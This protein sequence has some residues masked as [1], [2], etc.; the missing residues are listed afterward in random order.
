MLTTNFELVKIAHVKHRLEKHGDQDVPAID[1]KLVYRAKNDVLAMFSSTLKSSLY[2]FDDSVQGQVL[3]DP[4]YLPNVKNPKIEPLKWKEKQEHMIF[5]IHH[6][7]TDTEAMV[8][9]DAKASKFVIHPM[10]GG[11]VTIEFLVQALLGDNSMD[12]LIHLEKTEVYC[13]LDL[14]EDADLLQE[15]A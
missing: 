4:A 13:S 9:A 8:F 14:D 11:T 15:A 12:K 1:M 2:Y 10:E 6:G 7:V 5:R 3:D